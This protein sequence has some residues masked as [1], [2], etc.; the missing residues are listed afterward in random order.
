M[1]F[2]EEEHEE[3]FD[4]SPLAFRVVAWHFADLSYEKNI[5]PIVY[6]YLSNSRQII[7]ID[8]FT[9]QDRYSSLIRFQFAAAM[10][11]E[12]GEHKDFI[13]EWRNR[14]KHKPSRVEI[15]VPAEWLVKPVNS[16][17]YDIR[18]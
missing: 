14:S 13:I 16:K 6:S 1:K 17:S 9:N 18:N 5:I 8:S 4:D 7:F 3:N 10:R 11:E 2:R 15:T 12:F